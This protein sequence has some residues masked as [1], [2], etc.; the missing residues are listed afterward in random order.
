MKTFLRLI[1]FYCLLLFCS[2]ALAKA[3][4]VD[5]SNPPP[6]FE[7][8]N[9]KQ[10]LRVSVLF[11]GQ[12]IGFFF[13]DLYQGQL[14]FQSPDDLLSQLNGVKKN[15]NVLALLKQSF[16]LNIECDQNAS[17][18]L[19]DSCEKLKKQSVYIIYNPQQE[20]V[21]LYLAPFYF[22]RPKADGVIEFIPEPTSGW[23][24]LNKLGIAGS[25]SNSDPFFSSKNY[26]SMPNYYN[27]YSNNTLNYENSSI[28][29]NISQN[30]GINNGEHFQVQNLYTQYISQDKVY[31]SGY[32]LNANS[33]FFQ[34]QTILGA[35]IKTTLETIKNAD[36]IMATPLVIFVPNPSQV[37]IFKNE[38]LI[39]SEYLATGYQRI[40]TK[41]FPDGGYELTIKI[42]PSTIEH[43]FFNKG[44]SLPPENEP[45]FYLVGGYLTNGMIMNN[46]DYNFLPNVL[47]IPLLQAGVNKRISER[48]ALFSDII[49]NSHQALFD[50]GPTFF[51]GSSFVKVAGLITTKNNYGIYTML[52]AQKNRWNMSLIMT[53]IFY[54]QTTPDYFFLGNLVDNNS[55][56]VSY[57]L[58][59]YSLIGVQA[60]YN[61]SLD[62]LNSYNMGAFYLLQIGN[63]KGMGFFFNAAYNKTIYVGDTYSLGLSINFSKNEISGTES[64][65]WQTQ[66]NE[67]HNNLVAS[68]IIVQ[69]NTVYSHQNEQGAGYSFNEIHTISPTVSSI[70]GTYDYTGNKNY[71]ATYAN[72]NQVNGAGHSIGYGGNLE[73]ELAI[74]QYAASFNG[75]E[76]GNASG[77]IVEAYASDEQDKISKFAL[78]DSNNRKIAIIPVNKKVFVSLPAFTD[79][80][81]MLVNLSST[82]YFIKDPMRHVTLYPGNIG[83]YIWRVE[84]RI[85]VIGRIIKKSSDFPLINTWVHVDDNGVFTDN[86]GHFQLELPQNTKTLSV[87]DSCQIHLPPLNVHQAYLYVGDLQCS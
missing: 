54:Q 85:I 71:V 23:S 2:P 63:Y 15:K 26:F 46:N 37:S 78:M 51:L 36:E 86:E 28:I 83:H 30:N 60:N 43:R 24:Y 84:K 39:F 6:G 29:G 55:T 34:S 5:L 14:I 49:L 76:R 80:N 1:V 17:I 16:P 27:V 13:A 3:I 67:L 72:Y 70:A 62:Q 45:Q 8:T 11:M 19:S 68:P 9:M 22:E 20:T 18:T 21:Y 61:K 42:G 12:Q 73:T 38:Q 31:T 64:L 53:K 82:D 69:G 66:T 56:S 41:G 74:N 75:I 77:V 4:F 33:P 44:L 40:S 48:T 58:S 52:N 57:R 87:D 25:F 7:P 59:D 81:Y 32:I 65:S 50:F 10:H 79:Q 47:N 35:G